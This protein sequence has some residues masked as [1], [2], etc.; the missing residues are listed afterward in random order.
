MSDK[1]MEKFAQ[2]PEDLRQYAEAQ[3]KTILAQSQKIAKLEE[4]KEELMKKFAELSN[5]LAGAKAMGTLTG[6]SQF[7]VD[8]VEA[9]SVLQLSRIKE[10]ALHRELTLEETKKFEIFSKVLREQRG[11]PAR[12]EKDGPKPEA[13]TNEELLKL[14]DSELEQ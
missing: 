5:D 7:D 12:N 10:L 6:N 2:N 9:T 1:L 14:I 11:K 8:D 3:Y 4:E 13:M